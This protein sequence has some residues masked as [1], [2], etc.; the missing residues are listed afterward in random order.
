MNTY[1][2]YAVCLY[3]GSLLCYWSR[4]FADSVLAR[5]TDAYARRTISVAD[6]AG[7]IIY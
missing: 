7:Y 1:T 2:V 5:R 3:D 6:T 4:E